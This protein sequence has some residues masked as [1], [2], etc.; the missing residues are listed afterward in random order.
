MAGEVSPIAKS[1]MMRNRGYRP[2][3]RRNLC[4]Q[5]RA[6]LFK[7]QGV[8]MRELKT[9]ELLAEEL[10]ALKL[11]HIDQLEQI[12]AAEQMGVSQP[13]FS[14]IL[15]SAYEKVSRALVEGYAIEIQ[16]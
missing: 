15:G 1:V 11:Y 4:V 12:A 14:R 7:P 10:E 13:T 2:R 16:R 9:I 3:R 6:S 8:P 5:P